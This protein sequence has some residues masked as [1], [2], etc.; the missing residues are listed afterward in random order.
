MSDGEPLLDQPLSHVEHV[1][2]LLLDRF[3]RADH[4]NETELVARI[5][6]G[7]RLLEELWPIDCERYVHRFKDQQ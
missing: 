7:I 6:A 5:D 1:Y 3:R 2:M 4:A